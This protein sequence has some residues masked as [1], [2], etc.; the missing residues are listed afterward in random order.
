MSQEPELVGSKPSVGALELQAAIFVLVWFLAALLARSVG[1]W[2][3]IGST[4]VFLGLVSLS[5]PGIDLWGRGR[6]AR[7]VP[8]GLF[9]GLAMAAVTIFLYD[10][11]TRAVPGLSADVGRLYEEFR[12][13]GVLGAVV[14]LPVIVT[15]EEIVW[16]GVVF[17]A[18]ARWM[19]PGGA[20]IVSAVLYTLAHAPYGST[21][22]VLAAF[23]AGTSWAL[24][25]AYSDSLPAVIVAHA[26][27][28]YAV[29]VLFR[30]NPGA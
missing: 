7:M 10:P 13:F 28:D 11:V 15:C 4:A 6:P 3:A 27:W 24:L 30:L 8:I 23:G 16:R 29:L 5:R 2:Q 19:S 14:L 18:A 20:A 21:A 17:G 12:S 9:I 22:I 25:R 1:I 26:V